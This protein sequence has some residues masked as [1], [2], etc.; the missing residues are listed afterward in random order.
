WFSASGE[1]DVGAD[2][3]LGLRALLDLIDRYPSSRLVPLGEG[4]FVSLSA[5][6]Q[7]QLADLR[8]VS[9]PKGKQEVA[10]HGLAALTLRDFFD[11]TVLNAD[12][13]WQARRGKFREAQAFEPRLP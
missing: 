8:S 11:S 7:Q 12:S 5:A 3:V 2:Q 4:A 9:R 13:G 6:F 10:L 1:L